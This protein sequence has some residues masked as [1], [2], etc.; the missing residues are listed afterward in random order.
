MVILDLKSRD[1]RSGGTAAGGPYVSSRMAALGGRRLHP[2][3]SPSIPGVSRVHSKVRRRNPILMKLK[4]TDPEAR[5]RSRI[6]VY[7]VPGA[8]CA[9]RRHAASDTTLA[10]SAERAF[11]RDNMYF[12]AG[13]QSLVSHHLLSYPAAVDGARHPSS[14]LHFHRKSLVAAESPRPVAHPLT[15]PTVT[16]APFA[17][18]CYL[19]A[20]GP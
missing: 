2:V 18:A 5:A 15:T 20:R 9:A 13:M 19:L 11:T 17:T 12:S 3:Q 6:Q 14:R 7:H 16:D 1:L 4:H 8:C 10:M